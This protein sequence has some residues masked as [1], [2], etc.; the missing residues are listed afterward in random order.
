M[1]LF[2]ATTVFDA[3]RTALNRLRQVKTAGS[4]GIDI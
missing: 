2:F 1:L 4:F 3:M